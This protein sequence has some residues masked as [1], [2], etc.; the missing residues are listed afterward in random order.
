MTQ[1]YSLAF[2]VENQP[3]QHVETRSE[4]GMSGPACEVELPSVA[5]GRALD[6]IDDFLA[7]VCEHVKRT[8]KGCVWDV[9]IDGRP[10]HVAIIDSRGA[11]EISAGCNAPEDYAI[12]RRLG[13]GLAE[14]LGGEFTEPQK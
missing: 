5:D 11:I 10:A 3:L 8:R 1:N 2:A 12:L 9:W 7:G 4:G 14:I 13:R 6:A